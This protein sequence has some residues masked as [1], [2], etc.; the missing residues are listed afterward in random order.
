MA[1]SEHVPKA[2]LAQLKDLLGDKYTEEVLLETLTES[3]NDV[4]KAYDKLSEYTATPGWT[5]A[6]K[7]KAEKPAPSKSARGTSS[8]SSS[9]T[10]GRGRGGASRGRDGKPSSASRDSRPSASSTEHRGTRTG[11]P[12]AAPIEGQTPVTEVSTSARPEAPAGVIGAPERA[13]SAPGAR[14]GAPQRGA[15]GQ[16]APRAPRSDGGAE[17]VRKD[18]QSQ[19]G[20]QAA[21]GRVSRETSL[22]VAAAAPPAPSVVTVT[23]EK[24]SWAHIVKSNLPTPQTPAAQEEHPTPSAESKSEAKVEVPAV[25][26][27][28]PAPEPTYEKQEPTEFHHELSAAEL[29]AEV[30]APANVGVDP[31]PALVQTVVEPYNPPQAGFFESD[32][33]LFTNTPEG[34]NEAISDNFRFGSFIE[35][36]VQQQE[37][38]DKREAL[39]TEVVQTQ[40]PPAQPTAA[41]QLQAA[42]Q[43]EEPKSGV[44]AL[45]AAAG[46]MFPHYYIPQFPYPSGPYPDTPLPGPPTSEGGSSPFHYMPPPHVYYSY[47]IPPHYSYPNQYRP[48]PGPYFPPKFPPAG[49]HHPFPNEE[50]GQMGLPSHIDYSSYPG[51]VQPHPK[52]P[53]DASE[54]PHPQQ[55]NGQPPASHSPSRFDAPAPYQYTWPGPNQHFS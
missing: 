9:L 18:S 44:R 54:I 26:N 12:A 33:P 1:G 8:P 6:G 39:P 5:Q 31:L 32:L 15:V 19:R 51:Y 37:H 3:S 22:R 48:P 28:A 42:T 29:A 21:R 10:G 25:F 14:R 11:A 36:S 50:M 2:K 27:P 20:Q 46:E 53:I 17:T 16:H 7:K 23:A 47:G 35:E 4:Q 38:Q 49:V 43:A 52:G 55:Q 40:L 45:P 34:F 41:Q 13:R 30:P 24:G